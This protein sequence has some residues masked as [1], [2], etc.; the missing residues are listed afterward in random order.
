M[1]LKPE[2]EAKTYGFRTGVMI[3]THILWADNVFLFAQSFSMMQEM[4]ND[5]TKVLAKRNLF[6]KPRSLEW[7]SCSM[8]VS[9]QQVEGF[10]LPNDQGSHAVKRVQVLEA[11]GAMIHQDGNTTVSVDHRISKAQ[12]C[13]WKYAYIWYCPAFS[14]A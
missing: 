1:E 9:A 12:A 13:F 14:F 2:W 4:E 10:R 3:I 5:V 6:W 11:L 7:L 8:G